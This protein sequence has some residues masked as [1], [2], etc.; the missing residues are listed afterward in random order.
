LHPGLEIQLYR[1]FIANAA[2]DLDRHIGERVS[3]T[4]N[5]LSVHRLAGKCPIQVDQVQTPRTCIHP[6]LRHIQQIINKNGFILHA[7]LAKSHT[8]TVL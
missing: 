5:H 7:P 4:P 3:D 2:A 8:F 1:V 6:T